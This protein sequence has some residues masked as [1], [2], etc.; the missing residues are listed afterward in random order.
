VFLSFNRPISRKAGYFLEPQGPPTTV[1][2]A[3]VGLGGKGGCQ[4]GL[5]SPVH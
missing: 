4:P 1:C 5:G 3:P 2:P